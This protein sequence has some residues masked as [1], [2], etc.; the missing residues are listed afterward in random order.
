M[1]PVPIPDVDPTDG[2]E[3]ATATA[4][5]GIVAI[6]ILILGLCF[7]IV[8]IYY[9]VK[10]FRCSRGSKDKE[11]LGIGSIIGI[12]FPPLGLIFGLITCSKA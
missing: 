7:W 3:I 8:N 6:I 10:G 9:G 12:F 4:T 2:T 1:D 11:L 5:F